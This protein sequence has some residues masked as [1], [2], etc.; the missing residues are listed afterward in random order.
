LTW[1]AM[2]LTG[3]RRVD[4]CRSTLSKPENGSHSHIKK[5]FYFSCKGSTVLR[6]YAVCMNQQA[7]GTET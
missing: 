3:C 4:A 1:L 6:L 7:S 5:P 2:G